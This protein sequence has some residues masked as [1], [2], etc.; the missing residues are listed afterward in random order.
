MH[1]L[2][3]SFDAINTIQGLSQGYL[4]TSPEENLRYSRTL[5]HKGC[6]SFLYAIRQS[7]P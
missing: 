6:G 1:Y 7:S 2:C 3:S 4:F 5:E